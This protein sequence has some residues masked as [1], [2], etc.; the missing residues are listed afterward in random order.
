[1]LILAMLVCAHFQPV[2][3]HPCMPLFFFCQICWRQ[4]LP[5]NDEDTIWSVPATQRHQLLRRRPQLL[6][7]KFKMWTLMQLLQV[8]TATTLLETTLLETTLLSQ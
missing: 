1:M 7:S 5:L 8:L 6:W 3:V 2:A 4:L